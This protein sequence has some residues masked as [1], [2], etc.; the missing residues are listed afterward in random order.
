MSE[1]VII[2]L[3]NAVC[4]VLCMISICMTEP[5]PGPSSNPTLKFWLTGA[6]I[7]VCLL[8]FGSFFLIVFWIEKF[9]DYILKNIS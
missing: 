8:L 9:I 5:H 7:V 1:Y 4:G 6:L 2:L 3:L